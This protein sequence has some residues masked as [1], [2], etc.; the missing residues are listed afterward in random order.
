[1]RPYNTATISW[2]A[3]NDSQITRSALPSVR[4]L[5]TSPAVSF[6]DEGGPM[7]D[8][9]QINKD[10]GP[11][12]IGQTASIRRTFGPRAN[13]QALLTCG[14]ESLA[15]HASFDPDYL[16]A[17]DWIRSHAVGPAVLSPIL[18]SGLV[19]ALV[20]A[21]FPFSVPDSQSMRQLRP[22]IVGASVNAKIEVQ[23]VLRES[24]EGSMQEKGYQVCLITEVT[25][26]RDDAL[27]AEGSHT[28][29]IPDYQKM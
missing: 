1:M 15:A 14:G 19:G 17:K 29:W 24:G 27:I 20:E 16:R 8:L 5:S 3:Y 28:V 22:L 18:I 12:L 21:A 4:Q 26:V 11:S 6:E 9:F 10:I 25:R 23:D 13:A 7:G 2:T